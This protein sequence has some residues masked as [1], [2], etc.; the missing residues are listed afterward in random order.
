MQQYDFLNQQKRN[1]NY[2]FMQLNLVLVPKKLLLIQQTVFSNASWLYDFFFDDICA[3]KSFFSWII[4]IK[5]I[6]MI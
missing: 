1:K 4:L 2:V 5:C 3:T 6:K